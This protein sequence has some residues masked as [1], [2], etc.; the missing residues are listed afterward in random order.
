MKDMKRIISILTVVA[1]VLFAGY[2]VYKAQQREVLSDI[3]MENVEAL[4]EG[5]LAS[6]IYDILEQ[7]TTFAIDGVPYK[8]TRVVNCEMG[9]EYACQAGNYWR[10]KI[11]GVWSE[12]F[13]V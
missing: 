2:N 13:Y 3:A 4:A 7:R 8:E 10:H 5:E 12:W 6:G 9:G 11:N 1:V